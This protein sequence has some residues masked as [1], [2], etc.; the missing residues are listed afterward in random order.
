MAGGAGAGGATN[1]DLK[2]L[3]AGT[4]VPKDEVHDIIIERDLDQPDMASFTL[5]NESTKY[6]E[7]VNEGDDVEVK[8]GLA[9]ERRRR[10][11]SRVRSP[12][13][14]RTTRPRPSGAS[15]CAR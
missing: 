7:K 11:S 9:G 5:S 2:V 12:A 6:S 3:L 8:M 1:V 13:S 4:E 14:S 15:S 10:P